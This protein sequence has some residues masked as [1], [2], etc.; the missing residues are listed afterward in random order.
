MGVLF[1][2]VRR[3]LPPVLAG[4]LM[5]LSSV[6]VV[7]SSLLLRLYAPPRSVRRIDAKNPA[8]A[9]AA[10]T[11]ATAALMEGVAHEGVEAGAMAVESDHAPPLR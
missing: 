3:T 4:L 1:P 9:T 7:L 5:A 10:A 6:S 2:L 11:Q 8:V